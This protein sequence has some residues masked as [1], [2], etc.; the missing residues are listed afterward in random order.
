M[1]IAVCSFSGAPGVT[2]LA[3]ALAAVW[4]TGPLT[5]PVLVEADAS[6]GDLAV[7]HQLAG[8]PGLVS[9]AASVRSAPD[10]NPDGEQ[11]TRRALLAHAAELP[12][13]LRA[14]AAP[15]T[16][17]E[18]SA[19]VTALAH[20]A[21]ILRGGLTVLDLGRVAP[22][23]AGAHLL[24]LSDAVVLTVAGDD[25]AQIHR[26][27]R[28]RDV[29]ESLAGKG[30]AVGLAVHGSRFSS[31]EIT[32]Q[33]GCRVWAQLPHDPTGA[34]FLR[35]EDSRPRGL[36]ERVAAW[37]HTRHNPD[38]VEWMPLLAAARGLA[39][40]VDDVVD[41]AATLRRFEEAFAA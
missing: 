20:R 3:T 21:R 1:I 30:A 41:A 40:R 19:V 9:L 34:A 14:L 22:G 7:W 32:A 15:T 5:V 23:S 27:S 10:P 26:V 39:E 16:A 35:G 28:C 6:G 12:G 36:R 33:T 11:G 2:T 18:A 31:G 25:A 8:R 24:T 29:L 13:G 17:H 4:P 38:G 37:S